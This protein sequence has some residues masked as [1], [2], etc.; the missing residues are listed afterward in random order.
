MTGENLS[1]WKF[2]LQP[3]VNRIDMPW[4]AELL[5]VALDPAGMPCVWA[6]VALAAPR[7]TRT[8]FVCGTGHAASDGRYVG[9]FHL[10]AEGLVFHAFDATENP[11]VGL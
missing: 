3:G 11:G 7:T 5:H 4:G 2:P 1:V 8:V 10:P 6:R 9:T